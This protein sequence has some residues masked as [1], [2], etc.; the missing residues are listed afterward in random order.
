VFATNKNVLFDEKYGFVESQ[1]F[2]T[3]LKDHYPT[4]REWDEFNVELFDFIGETIANVRQSFNFC[5]S[6]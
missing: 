2:E 1:K 3:S 5:V 4:E 6:Y